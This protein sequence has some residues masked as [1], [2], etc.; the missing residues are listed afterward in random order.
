MSADKYDSADDSANP[1]LTP[2]LSEPLLLAPDPDK[3][4]V[5][6]PA[7]DY[8]L[9]S[10][11]PLLLAFDIGADSTVPCSGPNIPGTDAKAYLGPP[12]PPPPGDP[13]HEA[14]IPGRQSG[15]SNEN[16]IYLVKRIDALGD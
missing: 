7:P 11:Q 10:T 3:P 13:I 4:L 8:K 15:Y 14:G 2:V 16:R 9:D 1:P 12:P 6:L 5:E